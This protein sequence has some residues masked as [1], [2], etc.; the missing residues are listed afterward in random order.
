M[1]L[2]GRKK[3]KNQTSSNVHGFIYNAGEIVEEKIVNTFSYI[4]QLSVNILELLKFQKDF[5]YII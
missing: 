4:M 3:E 1:A 5:A 2:K